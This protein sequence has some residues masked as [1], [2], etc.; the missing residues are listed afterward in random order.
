MFFQRFTERFRQIEGQTTKLTSP[1]DQCH[2][3]TKTG[4][5]QRMHRQPHFRP[6]S[7]FPKSLNQKAV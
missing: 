6:V 4:D 7:R 5:R 1:R 3:A 2:A